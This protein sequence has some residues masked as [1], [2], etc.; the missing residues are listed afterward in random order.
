MSSVDPLLFVGVCVVVK[1]NRVPLALML[2]LVS[3]LSDVS[4]PESFPLYAAG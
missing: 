1:F 4:D 2:D 3:E